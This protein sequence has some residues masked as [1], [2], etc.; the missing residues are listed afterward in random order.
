MWCPNMFFAAGSNLRR[1]NLGEIDAPAPAMAL[2]RVHRRGPISAENLV[3]A[4]SR[5]NDGLGGTVLREGRTF[6]KSE[7]DS[8]LRSP[9]IGKDPEGQSKGKTVIESN[10]GA[11]I[12]L[13]VEYLVDNNVQDIHPLIMGEVEKRL[14]IKVLERSRG[15]KRQAAKLL[16]I[17]RNTFHRK[18]RRLSGCDASVEEEPEA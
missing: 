12:D 2:G 9:R 8:S 13:L 18:I 16:G 1:R 14:I 5:S 10:I 4:G 3:R 15:N 7:H 11:S 17:S 6:M